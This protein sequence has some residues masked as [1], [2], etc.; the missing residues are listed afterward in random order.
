M[1]HSSGVSWR[2]MA[3]PILFDPVDSPYLVPSDGSF[4]LR[5]VQRPLAPPLAAIIQDGREYFLYPEVRFN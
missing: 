3:H 5:I 2:L 1:S 4:K